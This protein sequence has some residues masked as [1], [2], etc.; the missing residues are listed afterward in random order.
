MNQDRLP[1]P[2]EA[3]AAHGQGLLAEPRRAGRHAGLP[4]LGGAAV[5]P[6][7]ARAARRRDRSEAVPAPD[8]GVARP[9]R[10]DRLPPA[11]A[12]RP[13]LHEAPRGGRAGAAQL[14]RHGH[15]PARFG[16]PGPGREPRG[17]ADQDRGQPQAPRQRGSHRRPRAGLGARPVRPR[18]LQ[19]PCSSAGEPSTWQDVRRLRR[20][21]L[22]R[23]PRPEGQGTAR[24]ERGRGVAR[25]STCCASTCGRSCRRHAGTPIE[26][27]SHGQR[28]GGRDAGLR[29]AGRA[30]GTSSIAPRSSWRS[31]A[32]SSAWR[33]M[34]A[35]I[36]AGSPRPGASRSAG[37]LDEPA[38]RGREPVS[39]SR[40]AWPITGSGSRRAMWPTT[41]W[42]WRGSSCSRDPVV[43]APGSPTGGPATRPSASFTAFGRSST[44]TG[45]ARWPPTC[46][47]IAGR[48]SSS[49]AAASRPLVHALVHA[50]NAALGNLGKTVELRTQAARVAGTRDPGGTGRGDRQGAGR[51]AGHPRRQSR[52]QRAGRPRLR[53][54]DEAGR[55]H[56]PAGIARR[57]DL[58]A[59]DLAPARGAL[60][61]VVGR[62][63]HRRRDG[64]A[65]PAAD[66]A[67][68]RRPDGARGASPGCPGSRRPR[69]TRSSAARSGRSAASTRPASRPP[70]GRFLHDG[71]LAG[72]AYPVVQPAAAVGRRSARRSRPPS[73]PR[74]AL[75]R[76]T[77]SW[78]S[79]ATPRSTTAGSPTT[80]GCRRSPT[81]SPS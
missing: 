24:A 39:R 54:P 53:R 14:L 27:I 59:G 11:R 22:R 16:L 52:V 31:T 57:R 21:S 9:G 66:R 55:D 18:P 30:R 4:R 71:L 36:S 19:P 77:S 12:P 63:P 44:G 32:T 10:A 38:L 75:G 2:S 3:V 68:L 5:S 76:R 73:R 1:D 62:C 7:D 43:P 78:S 70:G 29:L 26:P 60:P 42:R 8:G 67:A 65:D 6:V 28:P 23:A 15:A 48:A 51:D 69:P 79:T 61:G 72:S 46:G 35:V 13:P 49:R 47:R 25:R 64:R 41:P 17:A 81:R 80:A 40:A 50:M 33:T 56:D 45:S 34:A 58:A 20:R 37:R 74:P